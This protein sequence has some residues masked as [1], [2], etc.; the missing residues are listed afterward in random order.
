MDI[1]SPPLLKVGRINTK[2]ILV[3]G[4]DDPTFRIL[5][6]HKNGSRSYTLKR[7]NTSFHAYSTL[8]DKIE[9]CLPT[10]YPKA[11]ICDSKFLALDEY[12]LVRKIQSDPIMKNIPF[13]TISALNEKLDPKKAFKYSIDDHYLISDMKWNNLKKRIEFLNKFKPEIATIAG[14][15]EKNFQP[16]K[17]PPKKRLFDI[18]FASCVLL[19]ISPLLILVALAVKLGS[20]GPIFYTSQ[21]AGSG[22][23][24]FGFIKFRSMCTDADAKLVELAHL[25]QYSG[26]ST[27][28]SVTF[29]KIQDDPR[30]TKVGKLIRKTSID[31]LPQLFNVLKGDMSIVGNRPLPLYEAEQL[32]NDNWIT[33]FNAPAGLTGLWQISKRGKKEMSSEERIQLDID[34]AKRYSVRMDLKILLKTLPAMIQDEQV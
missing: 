4:F 26:A 16:Y 13:I 8:K 32:T 7:I 11:I 19:V 21:R 30:V 17:T 1:L 12:R 2:E 28:K 22:Y 20:K 34:Y 6:K 24:T 31:E 25:N 9:S 14:Q 29:V 10:D 5:N 33:R 27:G 23:N 15:A 3:V 18:L